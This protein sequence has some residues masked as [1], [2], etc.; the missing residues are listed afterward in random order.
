[1]RLKFKT[2]K[3]I[4]IIYLFVFLLSIPFSALAAGNIGG[5]KYAWSNN[6]G[7]IN[8]EN[9]TVT[10]DALLGY[11]WSKNAGWIRLD[12]PS[13]GVKNNNGDLSGYA[14]GEQLGWINF[15]NVYIDT[16]TGK[17]SGTATGDRIGILTFDCPIYCDVRTFWRPSSSQANGNV[18]GFVGF[19]VGT[20]NNI[21]NAL[22]LIHI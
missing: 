5:N 9:V 4:F 10:D 3:I 21:V 13:G 12:P 11:A 7:Y 22:S 8:F 20:N 6:V 15:D 16:S 18:G 19:G 17:F 14:W 1:M 2:N